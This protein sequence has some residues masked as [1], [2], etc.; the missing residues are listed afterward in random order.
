MTTVPSITDNNQIVLYQAEDGTV[1]M[2][3][4]LQDE[5]IWLSQKQMS[6]LFDK[7]VRTIN[8]HIQNIFEDAEL[9]PDTTIR[10]FRIVQNE[11]KRKVEREI[12]CYN[13]DVIISVGYRVSSKRGTQFRIW[14][15]NVLRRHLIEGY[16]FHQKR[17]HEKGTKELEQAL[18]LIARAKSLPELSSD[19][20]KGLLDIVTR[21]A[22]TWLLLRKYDDGVMDIPA[23]LRKPVYRLTYDDALRNILTLKE[24]LAKKGEASDLFGLERAEMLQSIIGNLYQTFDKKELYPTLEEKA[25]HL[26]YFVIK[27]HPFSDGNKRI[28]VLLFLIFLQKNDALSRAEELLDSSLVALALLIAESD[29]KERETMTR[30]VLHFIVS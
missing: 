3:V 26:L 30:L 4:R 10:K 23:K 17:L 5:T 27:D 20:A 9:K 11:G 7:G 8:E 21:Y 13:L 28:A 19:E 1:Q 25:A 16:T 18:A 29:P 2:D 24:S 6:V 14:A 12:D 22:Q 15:T